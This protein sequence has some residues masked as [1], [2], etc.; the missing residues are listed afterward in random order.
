[1]ISREL[2]ER[3]FTVEV[4]VLTHFSSSSLFLLNVQ[5]TKSIM[6]FITIY[7]QHALFIL[8]RDLQVAAVQLVV[9]QSSKIQPLFL[10]V[11]RECDAVLI[12][13]R[14]GQHLN[15]QLDV[16]FGECIFSPIVIDNF[17]CQVIAEGLQT[18]K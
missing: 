13:F 17:N 6:F 2:S 8:F 7:F 5:I 15:W 1:L 12:V 4:F 16:F 10:L 3:G 11:Q 9:G 18:K 14:I